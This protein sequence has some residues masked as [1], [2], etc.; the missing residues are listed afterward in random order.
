MSVIV[1]KVAEFRVRHEGDR[2]HVIVDG[3]CV[4]DLAHDAAEILWRAIRMQTLKAEEYANA[5]R[6]ALD[7]AILLRAGSRM[8][9]SGDRKIVDEAKKLAAH[10]PDLRRYMPGIKSQ[11]AFGTPEVVVLPPKKATP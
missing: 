3:R 10:D 2:V 11:E 7:S 9:L 1:P 5:N 8:V 4:I 6:V